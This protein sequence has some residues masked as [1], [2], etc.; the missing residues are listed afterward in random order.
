M[1]FNSIKAIID[2]DPLL[3]PSTKESLRSQDL[4]Q[5]FSQHFLHSF[6]LN[7]C[8]VFRKVPN[9]LIIPKKT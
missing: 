4:S 2:K 6:P 1:E 7:R 8:L 3:L 5:V 9:N